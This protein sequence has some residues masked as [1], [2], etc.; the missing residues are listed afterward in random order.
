MIKSN[1]SCSGLFKMPCPDNA[2]SVIGEHRERCALV[3]GL[4]YPEAQG[5]QQSL[6]KSPLE[7]RHYQARQQARQQAKWGLRQSV[8]PQAP[9]APQDGE[10]HRSTVI[11]HDCEFSFI[12]DDPRGKMIVFPFSCNVPW[13]G[14][15]RVIFM[16]SFYPPFKHG[17]LKIRKAL[18]KIYSLLLDAT[19]RASLSRRDTS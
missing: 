10:K 4:E 1:W 8:V 18:S 3:V 6:T 2:S 12:E 14:A 7:S 19:F 13:I 11:W 17:E 9:H 5:I 16:F 15:V